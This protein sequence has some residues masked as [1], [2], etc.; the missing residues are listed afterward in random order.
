LIGL[1]EGAT[2]YDEGAKTY[3]GES[4]SSMWRGAKLR[5]RWERTWILILDW[6]YWHDLGR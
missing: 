5:L 3:P 6:D 1:P 2:P 4:S